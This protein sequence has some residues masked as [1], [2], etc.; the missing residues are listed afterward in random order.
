MKSSPPPLPPHRRSTDFIVPL[1]RAAQSSPVVC[2]NMAA[3]F[4]PSL[5]RA[6]RPPPTR[7]STDRIGCLVPSDY[8][9]RSAGPGPRAKP[10]HASGARTVFFA[11]TS[12]RSTWSRT[13]TAANARP[14]GRRPA[15][16]GRRIAACL[17]PTGERLPHRCRVATGRLHVEPSSPPNTD[18]GE[19]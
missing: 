3:A 13:G 9:Y 2:T 19:Y 11:F 10:Q 5:R 7:T 18:P 6:S 15:M 14:H 16:S 4:E 17:R 1:A 8:Q 12:R